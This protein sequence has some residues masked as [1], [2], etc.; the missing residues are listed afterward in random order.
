MLKK[1]HILLGALFLG[2]S[3]K[4]MEKHGLIAIGFA[5]GV[6]FMKCEG[7]VSDVQKTQTRLYNDEGPHEN[8]V[9]IYAGITEKKKIKIKPFD[10]DEFIKEHGD[11]NGKLSKEDEGLLSFEE[12]NINGFGIMHLDIIYDGN[13][14]SIY[15][16]KRSHIPFCGIFGKPEDGYRNGKLG[17]IGFLKMIHR[18]ILVKSTPS[19]WNIIMGHNGHSPLNKDQI[20][21]IIEENNK[22]N[23]KPSDP[24]VK[25]DN[26]FICGL[27]MNSEASAK[28]DKCTLPSRTLHLVQCKKNDGSTIG[29]WLGNTIHNSFESVFGDEEE[30]LKIASKEISDKNS[31]LVMA[32]YYATEKDTKNN[33]GKKLVSNISKMIK[34]KTIENIKTNNCQGCFEGIPIDSGLIES[35]GMAAIAVAIFNK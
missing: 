33:C 1:Q 35:T 22:K 10:R 29:A 26:P 21:K 13:E 28:R 15:N 7:Y 25:F 8:I 9:K 23:N 11:K 17:S 18:R 14:I 3:I 31:F 30:G 27:L 4:P 24:N 34:D 5:L 32:L 19:K 2:M 16:A 12:S 6:G 20:K